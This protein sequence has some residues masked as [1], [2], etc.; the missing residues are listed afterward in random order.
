VT[1]PYEGRYILK[2]DPG[3]SSAVSIR[4]AVKELIARIEVEEPDLQF[5]PCPDGVAITSLA[6]AE[7]GIAN[8]RIN[9]EGEL[10]I[11]IDPLWANVAL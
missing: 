4:D 11:E 2:P 7:R 6:E 1:S 8:P 3:E 10:R 5:I 9:R